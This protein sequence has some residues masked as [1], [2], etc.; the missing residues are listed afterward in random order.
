MLVSGQAAAE[1]VRIGE[2]DQMI[3][4]A[5]P[6][7]IRRSG[8]IVRMWTL[9]DLKTALVVSG[10]AY[11]SAK[12]L[13][14]YD[15]QGERSR[16]LNGTAYSGRMGNGRVIFTDDIPSSWHPVVPESVGE[17]EWKFACGKE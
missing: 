14:E 5:N 11:L 6:T 17:G 2:N 13:Y 10:K 9:S 7:T 16:L 3:G 8:S 1:W 12:N 15:C 4:Y